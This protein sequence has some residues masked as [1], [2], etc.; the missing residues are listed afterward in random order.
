MG[1][2]LWV[3]CRLA[4]CDLLG[5]LLRVGVFVDDA[6]REWNSD[7][8]ARRLGVLLWVAAR[9]ER[10]GVGRMPHV[11]RLGVR[12]AHVELSSPEVRIGIG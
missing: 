1:E 5:A 9:G 7:G 6:G 8:D 11:A 12:A 2:R 4:L 3:A 10:E